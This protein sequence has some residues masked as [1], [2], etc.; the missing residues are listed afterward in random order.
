MLTR[1]R[2]LR[3]GG[4]GALLAPVLLPRAAHAEAGGALV[5]LLTAAR[6]YDSRESPGPF[7]FNGRKLQP[8][9]APNIS[10]GL[11]VGGGATLAVFL[12]VT[13]TETESSGFL[14]LVPT[15]LSGERPL[16]LT[17]NINWWEDGQTIGNASLVAVGGENSI[18][19][20]VRGGS[21]G[22]PPRAHV[23]IDVQGYVPFSS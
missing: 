19:V 7:H 14:T 13:V 23:I 5:T 2:L 6:V 3:A 8:G 22:R 18:E 4:A 17:S 9:D 21:A 10:V 16:P 11:A 15:D 1:R 20:H 12:N